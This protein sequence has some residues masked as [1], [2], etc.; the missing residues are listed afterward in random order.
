[1]TVRAR[2]PDDAP[3]DWHRL[4]RF[5]SCTISDQLLS[6]KDHVLVNNSNDN[7][8]TTVNMKNSVYW[9]AQIVEIRART[10][11]EVY[12]LIRWYYRPE[13]LPCGR[14]KYHGED[15]VIWSDWEQVISAYTIAA[16][17]SCIQWREHKNENE[18]VQTFYWRQ[19]FCPLKGQLT[20]FPF[21]C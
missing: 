1:M 2:F 15:E 20:V 14:Q 16:K 6:V 13:E 21:N 9:I 7:K 8:E 4:D 18:L 12:V 10:E 5:E 19:K 17:C 3:D 11:K